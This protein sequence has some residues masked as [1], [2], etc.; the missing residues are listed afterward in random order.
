V[1]I[2]IFQFLHSFKG[3]K[4]FITACGSVAK[5][6]IWPKHILKANM[7]LKSNF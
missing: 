3:P 6:N 2:Q 7:P 5:Q 4:N 1:P